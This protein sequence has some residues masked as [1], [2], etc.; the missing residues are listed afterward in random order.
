MSTSKPGLDVEALRKAIYTISVR[1]D[2]EHTTDRADRTEEIAVE[3]D[4]LSQ[5]LGS[6]GEEAMTTK[7]EKAAMAAEDAAFQRA[8]ATLEMA[9]DAPPLDHAAYR[10][11]YEHGYSAGWTAAIESLVDLAPT[12]VTVQ[13]CDE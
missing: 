8:K 9:L 11:G 13:L 7:S 12:G 2:W 6:Q 10:L 1:H 3:Y 5:A 4:R